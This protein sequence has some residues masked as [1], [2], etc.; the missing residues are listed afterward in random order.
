MYHSGQSDLSNIHRWYSLEFLSLGIN[1][2]DLWR[3]N[4]DERE[5]KTR[6][7]YKYRGMMSYNIEVRISYNEKF[8]GMVSYKS[9]GRQ[10][11]KPSELKWK[12][13]ATGTITAAGSRSMELL[14]LDFH[15]LCFL[16]TPLETGRKYDENSLPLHV[17][18]QS[19]SFSKLLLFP[20]HPPYRNSLHASH[21]TS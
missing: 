12:K 18:S 1:I 17:F 2:I 10:I 6:A 11:C 16:S 4:G 9:V 7:E 8:R 13:E 15:L 5:G 19:A 3:S 14:V 20:L 21:V